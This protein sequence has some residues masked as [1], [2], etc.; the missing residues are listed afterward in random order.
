MNA[1]ERSSR[2]AAGWEHFEHVADVGVRGFGPDPG[3]AFEQAARAMTAV[4]C[5]SGDIHALES[6]EIHCEAPSLDILLADWLNAVVFE[7]A[8]RRMLF[9]E[10]RV[11]IDGCSLAARISGETVDVAR[12]RPATEVKGATL[13]ELRVAERPEG[14][15]TA[16][17][18]LDV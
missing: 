5:D 16:Q 18:I 12:H 17:C 13:S 11:R 8:T 10:F 1:R 9:S 14:G 4:V 6:V 15:W 3:T 2:P 7:M